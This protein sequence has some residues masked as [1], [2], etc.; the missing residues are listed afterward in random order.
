MHAHRFA[1]L[2]AVTL[3]IVVGCAADRYQWN[4]TH[5]YLSPRAKQLPPADLKEIIHLISS[6]TP[7]IIVGIG[8]SCDERGLDS[9]HV[10]TGYT[11]ERVT[12][13]DLKKL[14]GK[15]RIIDHDDGSPFLSTIWYGC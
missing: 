4:L 2:L 8:Q 9:I 15:W 6:A 13:F 14:N 1:F 12:V 3:W 11:N 7:E 5:A 10:V